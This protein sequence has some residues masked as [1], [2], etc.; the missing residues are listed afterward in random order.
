[1]K[2][3]PDVPHVYGWLRLD[4]RG[5]WHI[6]DSPVIQPALEAFINRNY[7]CD[8]AG[9][10]FFQNGPQRVFATLDLT[11]WVLRLAPD[12]TLT[13]HTGARW[14]TA[15]GVWLDDAGRL[16][17]SSPAGLGLIHDADLAAAC[18]H[19]TWQDGTPA[20]LDALLE[21]AAPPT[22]IGLKLG[23]RWRPIHAIGAATLGER[24]GFVA[25]PTPP[26]S[27]T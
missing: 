18:E 17:V 20:R 10:W 3:W 12:G 4:M 16:L 19:L 7:L 15:H 11:P 25:R 21:N 27:S 24:F 2:K 14:P 8:D 22:G 26:R 9:R 6:K 1:M 13:A 23:A 5:R